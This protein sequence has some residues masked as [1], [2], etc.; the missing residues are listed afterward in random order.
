MDSVSDI[1]SLLLVVTYLRV[2]FCGNVVSYL[3]LSYNMLN[4]FP[5]SYFI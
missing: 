3:I 2:L 5:L 1:F 4:Y